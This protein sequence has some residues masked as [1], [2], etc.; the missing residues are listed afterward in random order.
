[1]PVAEVPRLHIPDEPADRRERWGDAVLAGT[2][3]DDVLLAPDGVGEWLWARWRSLEHAGFDHDRFVSVVAGYRRELWL[4]LAGER[5][6]EQCCSGLV[7][8]IGRRSAP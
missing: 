4:W 2:A 1:V 6:W 8:R 3:L 5:T 7:G